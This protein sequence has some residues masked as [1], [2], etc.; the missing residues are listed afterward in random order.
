MSVV[1]AGPI[2]DEFYS[3]LLNRE[4]HA[5]SEHL[6]NLDIETTDS[7]GKT[8]LMRACLDN[9]VDVFSW[10]IQNGA[11]I[12]VEDNTRRNLLFMAIESRSLDI[13][14]WLTNNKWLLYTT[15]KGETAL[16]V[17]VYNS[18]IEIVKILVRGGLDPEI[19]NR[20][21]K[22][23]FDVAHAQDDKTILQWLLLQR[24]FQILDQVWYEGGKVARLKSLCKKYGYN[25]LNVTFPDRELTIAQYAAKTQ[26]IRVLKWLK[27]KNILVNETLLSY[28]TNEPKETYNLL[29]VGETG[30][31]KSTFVNAFANYLIF[32]TLEQAKE[33]K[34]MYSLIPSNFTLT[35]VNLEEHL[36][37]FG[38]DSNESEVPGAS[39]T[40]AARSYVFEIG[41]VRIRL[42]DTPG[43]GDTRGIGKDEENFDQ[44]LT[45]IGELKNI[46]GICILLKP[47]NARLD[48]LFEYCFKELLSRLQKDA[49]QNIMFVFTN[50]RSTSYRPG[51]T[52]TP[53]KS[54]LKEILSKPP[55]IKIPFDKE[56]VFCMDN[57][58]F[59]FLIAKQMSIKLQ[60][61]ELK[62]FTKSWTTSAKASVN[63]LGYIKSLQ[64]HNI[65]ETISLNEARRLILR[66]SIPLAEIAELIE[67]NI[68][69]NNR[70]NEILSKGS[71]SIDE[72]KKYLMVPRIGL[73][74]IALDYPMT[75]CTNQKCVETIQIED[76]TKKNYKQICH[77]KCSLSGVQKE[78]I[79]DLRLMNCGAMTNEHNATICK[80]VSCGHSF[81]EHMHIYYKT[82]PYNY[83]TENENVARKIQENTIGMQDIKNKISKLN[84]R[85]GEYRN[86]MEIIQKSMAKFAH[87]LKNNAIT[88]Y[89]DTHQ[90]YIEYL[91]D[92]ESKMENG[93]DRRRIA[94]FERLLTTYENHLL[95]RLE[96]AKW[97]MAV[98]GGV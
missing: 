22:N 73:H 78:V 30:V 83:E 5:A 8:Y 11:N 16:H 20:D 81:G 72:L 1:P 94:N 52:I 65:Q 15:Y 36:I 92:R 95:L 47:N 41:N 43:I 67:N 17:A 29:L 71:K 62:N 86:E 51:D 88:P 64:P 85:N 3:I 49:S 18:E 50:S 33:S 34:T 13:V 80:H 2:L 98:T 27:S 97:K 90:K 77:E 93:G 7:N 69:R 19:Q 46:H 57:E 32:E 12:D 87:F 76:T 89:N 24:S 61:N 63:L 6:P 60:D 9:E 58:A 56:N 28:M 40:Q 23:G 10:L 59:R 14:Q 26:Q 74:I 25:Y 68:Q 91:I 31:G 39:A 84:E 37:K 54:I 45:V 66:L 21:R 70:Y 44:V 42:I 75:I 35:D 55:H 48:V 38:T 53:L 82:E 79:G 4:F 96:K